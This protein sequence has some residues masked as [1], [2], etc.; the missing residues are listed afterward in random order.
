MKYVEYEETADLGELFASLNR[1]TV[2]GVIQVYHVEQINGLQ[3]AHADSERKL[4]SS[5]LSANE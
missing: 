5:S 4:M 1:T 3:T 2:I